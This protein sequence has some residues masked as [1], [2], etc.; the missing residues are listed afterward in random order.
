MEAHGRQGRRAQDC[1]LGPRECQWLRDEQA[2]EF[3]I[4]APRRGPVDDTLERSRLVTARGQPV[5][6][7]TDPRSTSPT[8]TG[9][10]VLPVTLVEGVRRGPF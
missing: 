6:G 1:R 9:L 2:V 10:P 5:V 4:V 7:I 3:Q 8:R